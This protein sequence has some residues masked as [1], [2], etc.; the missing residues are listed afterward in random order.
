MRFPQVLLTLCLLLCSVGTIG[1]QS[2]TLVVGGNGDKQEAALTQFVVPETLEPAQHPTQVQG[3]YDQNA[4][5]LVI[6][7]SGR[8]RDQWVANHRERDSDIHEDDSVEIFLKNTDK[9]N[10]YWHIIINPKGGI[11]DEFVDDG[12]R[13]RQK[14]LEDLRVSLLYEENEWKAIVSIPFENIPSGTPEVGDTWKFNITRT[15]PLGGPDA[16][17]TSLA[18]LP[19]LNF[20]DEANFATL[21][22]SDPAPLFFAPEDVIPNDTNDQESQ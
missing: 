13:Y 11:L 15:V 5:R 2:P 6:T 7:A 16:D 22:F 19:E 21:E 18:P 10:T 8:S 17:Y 4:L 9:K 1:A 20:H 12:R 3:W 14:D